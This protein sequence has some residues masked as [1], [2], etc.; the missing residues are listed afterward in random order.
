MLIAV[1]SILHIPIFFAAAFGIRDLK[2][3]PDSGEMIPIVV[4]NSRVTG[5]VRGMLSNRNFWR[6]VVIAISLIGV[7]STFRYFDALYL[8]YITRAFQDGTTF[9]YLSILALNP[10]IVVSLTATGLITIFTNQFHPVTSMIIGSFFGGV[11]PFFMALGPYLIAIILYIVLTSVGE[12][13]WSIV[14]YAYLIG[15]AGEGEEGAWMALAGLPMFAAKM[16]TG[17][18]TGNLLGTYCPSLENTTT[19]I[20]PPQLGGDPSQCYSLAIWGIIGLTTIS[21]FFLLLMV[22]KFITVPYSSS[23]TA[24]ESIELDFVDLPPDNG[25][26]F[27]ERE[28]D[29]DDDDPSPAYVNDFE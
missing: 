27:S 4:E 22:R 12:V 11:A 18:L 26:L 14:T 10:A 5:K 16:L 15:M 29:D 19:V 1:T 20:S 28:E 25:D 17:V 7:K 3:D 8:P 24:T 2:M 13:T 21:S 23:D 6:A 9:P